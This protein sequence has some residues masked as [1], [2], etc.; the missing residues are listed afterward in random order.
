[1]KEEPEGMSNPPRTRSSRLRLCLW[2][3]LVP[4][5]VS[6]GASEDDN[7]DITGTGSAPSVGG[8]SLGSGGET[9]GGASSGASGGAT[10]SGGTPGGLGGELSASGGD[11]ELGVGGN[12]AK[13][14]G[15]G[16][17]L[18][19]DFFGDSRCEKAGLL[20]CD[21]FEEA[22]V[23]QDLWS[24]NKSSQNT[25]ELTQEFAARGSRS[26]HIIA[27]NGY[28]FVSNVSAFPVANN[29][30]YGRMFIRVKRF[31]TVDWAHWTVAEAEGTG[32]GSKIR[33]GGQYIRTDF[34]TNTWANRWG[35]GSDGGPTGDWTTP[36]NDPE[37][38]AEEPA[39][40]EWLCLEW[41]HLGSR[42]ETH[43]FLDGV[44]HP[45]LSTTAQNH[46]ADGGEYILPE[47]TGLS[48]GWVQY[49]EDPTPFEVWIDEVA[50][51]DKRIGCT[52]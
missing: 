24:I 51:N 9:S 26:V 41:A 38:K 2:S 19:G 34:D 6:C 50:L 12:E 7:E 29:D 44:E 49:Q 13:G 20:L 43:F 25:L 39:V 42:N 35:V 45:S 36:D 23:N 31:S 32:N 48:L 40:G 14:T 30:Y 16:G 52:L 15:G 5:A 18:P 33:V 8:S 27:D 17:S 11:S 4:L 47:M 22:A 46:G 21:G 1:M 28:A 3:A 37:G 10:P